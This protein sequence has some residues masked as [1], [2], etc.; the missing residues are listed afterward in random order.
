MSGKAAELHKLSVCGVSTLLF[1]HFCNLKR[2]RPHKNI[3]K[4]RSKI[5]NHFLCTFYR[6]DASRI[7]PI[8]VNILDSL[9]YITVI[10]YASRNTASLIST[11]ADLALLFCIKLTATLH[12]VPRRK[13]AKPQFT[14]D[15]LKR[16]ANKTVP[17]NL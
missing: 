7:I 1:I 2:C 9:N 13:I 3:K 6:H 8:Y 12:R 11:F 15:A 17:F 10:P 16:T 4:L 5:S 14:S